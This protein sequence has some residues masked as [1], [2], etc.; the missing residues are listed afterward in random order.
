M[1]ETDERERGRKEIEKRRRAI[2]D[3]LKGS[4]DDATPVC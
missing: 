1:L 3:T 4:T 2:D